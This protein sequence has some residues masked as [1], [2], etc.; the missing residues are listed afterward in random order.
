MINLH[1]ECSM[2]A[3]EKE[4]WAF[5]DAVLDVMPSANVGHVCDLIPSGYTPKQVAE[6]LKA[7]RLFELGNAVRN[8]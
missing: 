3:S 1:E 4:T 8:V 7:Q 5:I 2:T 6:E